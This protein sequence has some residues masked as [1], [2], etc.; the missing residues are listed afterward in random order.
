VDAAHANGVGE[1][2]GNAVHGTAAVES[3]PAAPVSRPSWGPGKNTALSLFVFV[4]VFTALGISGH[5][6]SDSGARDDMSRGATG[7]I[8]TDGAVRRTAPQ[9][10]SPATFPPAPTTAGADD[11]VTRDAALAQAR[12][13][14]ERQAW[15]CVRKAA[16]DALA[17]DA[18]SIEAQALLQRAVSQSGW[19]TRHTNTAAPGRFAQAAPLVDTSVPPASLDSVLASSTISDEAKQRAIRQL[20]WATTATAPG[21]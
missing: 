10:T 11:S 2:P 20:G 4:V 14:T 16:Y 19:Q 15:E 3:T 21:R 5:G 13:C 7:V 12:A 1:P 8:K 6:Q 18:N 9:P 17:L